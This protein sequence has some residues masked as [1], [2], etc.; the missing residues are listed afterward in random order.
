MAANFFRFSWTVLRYH[1]RRRCGR[2]DDRPFHVPR[3]AGIT[4]TADSVLLY[5]DMTLLGFVFGNVFCLF[6]FSLPLGI[7]F[8]IVYGVFSGIFLGSWIL[9]LAEVASVFPVFFRRIHLTEGFPAV[10][11]SIAVGKCIGTL[12][13]YFFGWQ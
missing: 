8:L 11:L 2:T 7:P 12:I 4:R 9:A 6:H 5:E 13:F 10:I 1:H 3:Y